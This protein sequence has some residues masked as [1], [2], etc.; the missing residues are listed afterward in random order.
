MAITGDN[1]QAIAFLKA[2]IPSGPWLLVAVDPERKKPPIAQTFDRDTVNEARQWLK[3]W[4]G[5]RNLYFHVNVSNEHLT[6]KAT[7]EQ[8]NWLIGLHVDVDPAPPP[9]EA[10]A[11]EVSNHY[12]DQRADILERFK[13]YQPPPTVILFSGGGYQGFWLLENPLEI[14]DVKHAEQLELYNVK[15]GKDLG[16][17]NTQDLSR[18]MRL[19][20]TVNLPDAKKR[21]KGRQ[22]AL[23]QVVAANWDNV[24]TLDAFTKWIEPEKKKGS[25]AKTGGK[26]RNGTD[27]AFD[28]LQNGPQHEG[29]HSYGGDRSKAMWAVL[30]RLIH[31]QFGDEEITAMLMDKANKLSEHVYDQSNPERYVKKQI[32]KARDKFDTGFDYDDKDKIIQSQKNIRLAI[33]LLGVKLSYDEFSLRE[34]IEGPDDEPLRTFNDKELVRLYLAIDEEFYFRPAKGYFEDVVLNECYANKY[35]PVRQ[36][37]DSVK[38]DGKPR[39]DT[40]LIDYG[41]APDTPY[42]RAVGALILIAAVRRVRQPGCKFDEMLVLESPEGKDKSTALATLAVREEWFSD[43]LPM[44]AD[45]K[46]VIEIMSGKWIIEAPELKG[47]RG[48]TEEHVKAFLSRRVDRARMSYD[49]LV[50]EAPR[51]CVVLSTTNKKGYLSGSTGNRR[52]W[53]VPVDAFDVKRLTADRDRLWAEAAAREAKGESIRLDPSLYGAAAQEQQE[54]NV[55]DPWDEL[56]AE[57]LGGDRIGRIRSADLWEMVNIPVDRRTQ[58][59]NLRLSDIMQGLGWARKKLRF[60]GKLAWCY[61]KGSD[62][63][64]EEVIT[65]SRDLNGVLEVTYG[66]G[67]AP[68]PVD[69]GRTD[70][71]P[72][73]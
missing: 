61:V 25:K 12:A 53:P 9:K 35:H 31:M 1:E 50:T 57:H 13:A 48:K 27:W 55:G 8:I 56:F 20:G 18:I 64:Q 36:Y 67:Q 71:I 43:S 47:M 7:K 32:A 58:G 23:A 24:Y 17:D 15:L 16:G 51:Q 26:K 65:M 54:R 14:D 34:T 41:G 63:Q 5:T 66:E 73:G 45:D 22:A 52:V 29:P 11:E 46:Q 69:T 60:G 68:L 39:V 40:W 10:S 33:D 6:I 2:W 59:H 70:D 37:L 38:H 3:Q 62:V 44:D 19:P 72:F 4:N 21:A 28:V 42:V 49:R 30:R